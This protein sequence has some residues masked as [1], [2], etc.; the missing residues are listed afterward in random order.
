MRKIK[1]GDIVLV[2][3]A[4][5][6]MLMQGS[7]NSQARDAT[8]DRGLSSA[9]GAPQNWSAGGRD[10]GGTYYSPLK[11]I[12]PGNIGQLGF[13]WQ[14]VLD[15]KRG[16]EATPIVIDGVI[17]TSGSWGYMYA[18]N[19]VTGDLLWRYDPKPAYQAARNPCCD[20]VNRGVA[21]WRGRVYGASVD[22]RLH[23]VDAATG[24]KIWEADTIANHSLP[25]SIT[26]A[27]QIAGDVVVIGNSGSDMGQGGVRGY[28]SAYD[29]RSGAFK[30]RFYIVPPN[31]GAAYENPELALADSTWDHHRPPQYKGGGTAWDGFAYD[32]GLKLVYFGTANAAPYDSRLLGPTHNDA[33]YTASIIALHSDT[34]RMAWYYQTTPDDHWDYDATQKMIL[35]DLTTDGAHRAVLMQASKNGFFYVLDRATGQLLSANNY[36]YVNW[37]KGVD[38]KTGRPS[39][40]LDSDWSGSPKVI[41]PSWAGGHTWNPMSYSP[42]T[43]LVYIPVLEAGSVWVDMLH[44][45]G[46]VKYANG[47]FTAN[48]IIVD[49]SY[50]AEDLKP[51]FGV[52][53]PLQSV[54]SAH[55]GADVRE[56]LRAWDPI[57][58]QIQWE[59]VTSAGVRGYDGGV[60]STASNLVF[61]GRGNGDL[62]VYGGGYRRN[63]ESRADRKPHH[64]RSDDLCRQ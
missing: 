57:K 31:V 4:V 7:A 6:S 10:V 41:Y 21:V 20:L 15:G 12:N 63:L 36:T 28:V 33:L 61:Q 46:S 17:Y 40:T 58:Q 8:P 54:R 1:R 23:A 5:S 56:A 64:G 49:D 45:G 29:L 25:Y 43:G 55:P 59:Q 39:T 2:A 3:M 53:P 37:A 22:G 50:V 18:L 47:V 32:P 9:A 27:P 13:A 44:N 51:L 14:Q 60:M 19:A 62:V 24:R 34:G 26:G 48:T 16:Q 35:T 38:L 52:L 30:W 42:A 11:L